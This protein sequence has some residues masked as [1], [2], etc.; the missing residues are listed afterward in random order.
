MFMVGPYSQPMAGLIK[1]CYEPV[2][3]NMPVTCLYLVRRIN[4]YSI[5]NM[6]VNTYFR[7]MY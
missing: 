2:C 3:S 5:S 4:L 6:I 1:A 7:Y